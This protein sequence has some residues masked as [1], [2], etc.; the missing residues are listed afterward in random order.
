[1]LV[2]EL[3]RCMSRDQI[4]R[5]HIYEFE[6]KRNQLFDAETKGH[7]ENLKIPKEV[8]NREVAYYYMSHSINTYKK[9]EEGQYEN[10]PYIELEFEFNICV[11]LEEY[12]I[13]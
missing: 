1:M 8:L 11:V 4:A 9:N 2:K 12:D 13:D 5:V 10:L 3:L 7:P 6:G